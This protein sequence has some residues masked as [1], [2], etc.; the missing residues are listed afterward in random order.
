MNL[1]QKMWHTDTIIFIDS[2]SAAV[3][4]KMSGDGI[5]HFHNQ[6]DFKSYLTHIKI[7]YARGVSSLDDR[8]SADT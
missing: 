3:F 7:L 1:V 2:Q 8:T 6:R 4:H 5:L